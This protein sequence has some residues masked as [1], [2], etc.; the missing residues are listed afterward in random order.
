MLS[1]ILTTR[2]L[3]PMREKLDVFDYFVDDLLSE[4]FG[5][6]KGELDLLIMQYVFNSLE[7]DSLDQFYKYPENNYIAA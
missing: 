5:L 6:L 1:I 2:I 7:L 4:D 3:N